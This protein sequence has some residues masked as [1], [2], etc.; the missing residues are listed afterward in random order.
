M[1]KVN[2]HSKNER[3]GLLRRR[4]TIK[5]YAPTQDVYGG[6]VVTWSDLKTV[7]AN[8]DYSN[9]T[10]DEKDESSRITA[11]TDIVFTIRYDA[12]ILDK[13][14][15]VSYRSKLYDI[16]SITEEGMEQFLI[17]RSELKE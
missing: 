11:F 16:K 10:S 13:K 3:I 9:R 2:E 5:S 14:L 1:I 12:T 17:L 4:I 7:W 15:R 8:V 6:E